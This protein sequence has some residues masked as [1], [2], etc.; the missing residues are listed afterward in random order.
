MVPGSLPRSSQ[1]RFSTGELMCLCAI[2]YL[3]I[4]YLPSRELHMPAEGVSRSRRVRLVA[5]AI[6]ERTSRP[7]AWLSHREVSAVAKI[8]ARDAPAPEI[9]TAYR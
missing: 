8:I 9:Q 6:L 2:A 1:E 5:R 7:G 4:P 3:Q